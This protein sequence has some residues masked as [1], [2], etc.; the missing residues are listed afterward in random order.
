[1]ISGGN[2]TIYVS[3]LEASLK[4]YTDILGF[5]LLYSTPGWAS[6]KLG[7]SLTLGLH[8]THPGSPQPGTHGSIS[9]GLEVDQPLEDVVSTLTG[10]GAT[11]AGPINDTG[12]VR[13]AFL[14]D[15]DGNELYLSQQPK[16]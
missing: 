11:F 8:P 5:T 13:L 4:F 10:R 3:N 12:F 14:S 15:P 7:D 16:R 9:I 6:V 1:M 2:A